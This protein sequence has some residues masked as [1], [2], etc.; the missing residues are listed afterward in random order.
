VIAFSRK[1]H[2]MKRS[3]FGLLLLIAT[4][5]SAADTTMTGTWNVK[6]NIA[7]KKSEYTCTFKQK[8]SDFSGTCKGEQGDFDITGKVDGKTISWQLKSNYNGEALTVIYTGTID[9]SATLAGTIDVQPIGAG[10]DFT[11]Q[12][13][14]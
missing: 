4:A 7:G 9:S 1:E 8:D 13:T 6:D 10:G 14:K 3:I 11:A 12:K 2:H 5:A